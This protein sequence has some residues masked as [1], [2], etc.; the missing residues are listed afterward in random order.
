MEKKMTLEALLSD[1]FTHKTA[2]AY[3]KKLE[4][5][6]TNPVFR[7]AYVAWAHQKGVSAEFSSVLGL[8]EENFH[9]YLSEYDFYKISPYNSWSRIWVNDKLTLRYTL[10]SK[11]FCDY[12][13]KYYYYTSSRGLQV[14]TD[15]PVKEASYE[16]FLS[17][18][19]STGAFACK[20]S[21][22]S[23]AEGFFKLSFEKGTYFLN[24]VPVSASDVIECVRS[25]S[26]YVF[27]EY[28]HPA[29]EWAVYSPLIHTVRIMIINEHGNDPR[30][31]GNYIRI[32]YKDAG[33]ANYILHDGTN[34]EKYNIYAFLDEKTGEYGNA[35]AVYPDRVEKLERHPDTGALLSGKMNCYQELL[36]LSLDIA[37]WYSNLE[38]IGFDFGITTH[39]IKLMEINTLPAVMVSQIRKPLYLD[40]DCRRYFEKKLL[41][42][43]S[44]TDEEKHIRN[45]ISR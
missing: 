13:P 23:C 21:N 15:N 24:S 4:A 41:E 2:V 42:I 34:N 11:E 3:L 17:V 27:T 28:L 10:S 45:N 9:N 16:A 8:N 6:K 22:G 30:I 33:E 5:E 44:M 1:G 26:N 39:G 25:H 32:P 40:A 38:F 20:P 14:L 31:I 19:R 12:L 35:L 36:S 43:D 18:L 7:Q 29:E 37:R